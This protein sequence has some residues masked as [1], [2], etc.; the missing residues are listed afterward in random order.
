[1]IHIFISATGADIRPGATGKPVPGYRA[2]LFDP[3]LQP[4]EGAGTGRLGVRGPTGCRY[5]SDPRQRDYVVDGW[6]MT[7]DIYRRDEDG[8]YW[9]VARAD[10]MIVSGGYN[11]AGPEVEAALASA[12]RCRGMRRG[13]LAGCR[14]RPDRQG[15]G[16]AKAGRRGRRPNWSKRC[17]SMSSASWRPTNIPARSNSA[18]PCPKPPP[19]NCS[20][21]PCVPNRALIC[22][23]SLA[24]QRPRPLAQI[25]QILPFAA[26]QRQLRA[27]AQFILRRDGHFDAIPGSGAQGQRRIDQMAA[28]DRHQIGAARP[29]GWC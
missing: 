14:A 11:I 12:S 9:F 27:I 3:D 13:R 28:A 20:A 17:R 21:A 18:T 2:Q 6:N 15:G 23:R 26:G 1:M 22:R 29:P 19:A 16:G 10:D 24:A 8:Y 25:G 7:G 5:L 4:I